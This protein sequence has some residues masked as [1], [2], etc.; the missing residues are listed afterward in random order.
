MTLRCKAG[1]LAIVTGDDPASGFI[2]R[3]IMRYDGPWQDGSN[4]AG[5][6]LDRP[7]PR[8]CG[9]FWP[10]VGDFRL[11]PIRPDADPS[12]DTAPTEVECEI[13]HG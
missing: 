8:P 9:E 6:Q 13:V 2:V 10:F 1:D 12:S 3:C 7:I 4:V 5:W 11:T